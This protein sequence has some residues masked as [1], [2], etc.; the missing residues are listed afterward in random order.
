MNSVKETQGADFMASQQ[1]FQQRQEQI[2]LHQQE[3]TLA[4]EDVQAKEQAYKYVVCTCMCTVLC[5]RGSMLQQRRHALLVLCAAAT[6]HCCDV[7]LLQH[8]KISLD[9][10]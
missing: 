5:S 9:S 3:H 6:L 4:S 7:L 1:E 2:T 8:N 10:S